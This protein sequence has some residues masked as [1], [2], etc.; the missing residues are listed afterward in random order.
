VTRPALGFM[1]ALA[2]SPACMGRDAPPA[3]TA[4]SADTRPTAPAETA[5]PVVLP[6]LSPLAGSVQHQVRERHAS[7]EQMR[8]NQRTPRAELA[9]AYGSLGR[10]LM[11]SKFT[12]EATACYLQAEALAPGEMRWPYYLGHAYLRKGDRVR[13]AAAFQRA[14]T[15]QPADLNA[16]I[17]L[18][19]TYLDDGRPDAAQPIF[20]QALSRQPQSAAALFGAGRTALARQAYAEAAQDMERALANDR[21]ASAIHYPLAMAYRALGDREKAEAQLRERGSAFPDLIDPLMQQDDEVLDSA[22]AYENRGVQ[23]LKAA[24]WPAA[25]AAFRKGLAL[26]PGDASLRY[27][28]GATRYAAGDAAAAEREFVAVVRHSPDFAKAHFSLGMIFDASGRRPA[29]IEQ[30]RAAVKHDPTLPEARF[31]LAE[32]LRATGQVES[33]LNEYEAAI[34]L[35]PGLAEAWIGGGRALV[36]LGRRQ[37]ASAWLAQ[38][39]RLHPG[40]PELA[41]MQ[42]RVSPPQR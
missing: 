39:R 16:L 5:P 30:F 7:L 33:S 17:W 22:V 21:Q 34:T 35:D 37:Q 19:E 10:L 4:S 18:G 31:R 8:A 9:A 15:L 42:S 12:D 11:A 26:S 14:S 1:I 28:L 38:A 40:R 29:A 23:A 25:A 20:Q 13:A 24:D 32:T 6:E 41:E 3:G 36:A 2:L 27:W